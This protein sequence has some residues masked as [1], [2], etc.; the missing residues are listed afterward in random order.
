MKRYL[1]II[2][3]II[4]IF[5][6]TFLSNNSKN[7]NEIILHDEIKIDHYLCPMDDCYDYFSNMNFSNGLCYFYSIDEFG[8]DLLKDGVYEL[9]IKGYNEHSDIDGVKQLRTNHQMHL[10]ICFLDNKT[11]TGSL[12]PTY[13]GFFSQTNDFLVIDSYELKTNLKSSLKNAFKKCKNSRSQDLKS[14]SCLKENLPNFR[15]VDDSFEILFS[16]F[17]NILIKEF[18]SSNEVNFILF[19]FNLEDLFNSIKDKTNFRLLNSGSNHLILNNEN[20]ENFNLI[21]EIVIH[22]KLFFTNNVTITGSF[23]PTN[24]GNYRN[25]ENLII[26]RNNSLFNDKNQIKRYDDLT[27][28]VDF[29]ENLSLDDKYLNK[30]FIEIDKPN[31]ALISELIF[32]CPDNFNNQF[33]NSSDGCEYLKINSSENVFGYKIFITYQFRGKNYSRKE[34]INSKIH[35]TDIFVKRDAKIILLDRKYNVLDVL[36]Y[37]GNDSEKL[38]KRKIKNNKIIRKINS[39]N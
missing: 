11:I 25:L 20:K 21:N 24:N 27:N 17:E 9:T 38:I 31:K 28:Y 23:N 19:Y 13:N 8:R 2:L 26:I 32:D 14:V 39:L 34:N 6:F 7:S 16:N 1:K 18:N 22:N 30:S 3:I 36:N 35:Q 33:N 10:K 12:N 4:L 5:I 15:T 37:Y 29:I